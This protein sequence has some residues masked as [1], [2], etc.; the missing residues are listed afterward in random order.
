MNATSYLISIDDIPRTVVNSFRGRFDNGTLMDLPVGNY[1]FNW[2][3]ED[4]VGGFVRMNDGHETFYLDGGNPPLYLPQRIIDQHSTS[5]KTVQLPNMQYFQ[6]FAA[7]AYD[8]K[9]QQFY[10]GGI[11]ST[12]NLT[13]PKCQMTTGGLH[14]IGVFPNN[15]QWY[16]D[17]RTALD[18]NTVDKPL[19]DGVGGPFCSNVAKNFL[20]RKY[21][22]MNISTNSFIY[23]FALMQLL[24]SSS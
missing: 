1:S 6:E 15:D 24:S 5:I 18:Q 23:I 4:H 14:L 8:M 22:F 21:N 20:N 16:F 17:P 11:V 7:A 13:D 9:R 10:I 2:F 19:S 3:T 12:V